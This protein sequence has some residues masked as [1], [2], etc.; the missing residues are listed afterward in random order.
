MD[1][2]EK[3]AELICDVFEQNDRDMDKTIKQLNDMIRK[4]DDLMF[5]FARYGNS[6]IKNI[7]ESKH[8]TIH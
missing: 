4:D 1:K 6:I 7:I 3:L 2:I 5:D 8:Q